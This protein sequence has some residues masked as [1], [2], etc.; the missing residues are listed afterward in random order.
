MLN[1]DQSNK[2][3]EQRPSPSFAEL[4]ERYSANTDGKEKIADFINS[5]GDK[6][7]G[8]LLIDFGAGDGRL[9]RNLL[10]GFSDIIAVEKE[11]GFRSNLH[12]LPG[13]TVATSSMEEFRPPRP[14]DIGLLSYSLSGIPKPVFG[15]TI[16]RFLM[17]RKSE[18]RL[19]FVTYQDGCSWD[20]YA[21][22][23]AAHFGEHRTG[24]LQRHQA[25]L[26]AAGFDSKVVATLH[27][28]IWGESVEALYQN[29]GFFC[30]Q[31]IAAY[32]Q[33]EHLLKPSLEALHITE[34]PRAVLPVIETIVEIA[35][36]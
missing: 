14:Y 25:E 24:G 4:F 11:Q 7:P 17:H 34:G 18:G 6:R 9:T 29:L 5:L 1:R 27:T 15:Q 30:Y 19:L 8:A 33:D 21:D 35:P 32:V 13:V 22:K 28:S 26:H 10:R 31:N 23:L 12:S 20:L 16:D 36:R 2:P 3:L